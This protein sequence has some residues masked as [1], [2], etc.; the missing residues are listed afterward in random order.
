MPYVSD[1][2]QL[3]AAVNRV[4]TSTRIST[5]EARADICSA[6]ADRK[7]NVR[8]KLEKT[9]NGLWHC[10]DVLMGKDFQIPERINPEEINWEQSRPVKPWVVR[11]DSIR[12]PGL[13]CLEWLEVSTSD[14]T[15]VLCRTATGEPAAHTSVTTV[16][17]RSRPARERAKWALNELYPDSVPK[18]A[19]V[20][21]WELCRKVS[22][23]LRESRLLDVKDDTILR[24]AGRRR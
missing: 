12:K 18:Q 5:E 24:A 9:V 13:W 3:S 11:P 2:E 23:K 21:N 4:M 19:V 17:S 14:I 7:I 15:R 22:E 20:P 1:W 6:I 16:R 10:S 8:G